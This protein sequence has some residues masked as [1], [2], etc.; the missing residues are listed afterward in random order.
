MVWSDVDGDGFDEIMTITV[1]T[2]LTS[3]STRQ[4]KVYFDGHSTREWE[5]TDPISVDITA[6]VLTIVF[7]FW[8]M[9]DPALQ[10]VFPSATLEALDIYDAIYVTAVDVYREYTDWSQHSAE[11]FWEPRV[12]TITCASC[13]GTGCTACQLTVQC[14]CLYVRDV[15]RGI[16]VPTPGDW[17][18]TDGAW[19]STAFSLCYEPDQVKLWYY[20]GDMDDDYVNGQ[21]VSPLK[22]QYAEA[23]AWMAT[24]RLERNFCNCGAL[25][26][27]A[28]DLRKDLS[29]L[30]RDSSYIVPDR[31]LDNP[32]GTRKGEVM[33][34]RRLSRLIKKR[35]AVALV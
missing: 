35:P 14:G 29:F 34:W 32:F 11:F 20:A 31:D 17:N 24:A 18:A 22:R 33:A 12:Q 2:T 19:A 13:G 9:I 3:N 16:V 25:T 30:G 8:S 6:G 4:I 21:A 27:L 1:A 5:I 28:T 26:A 23:I 7:N 15:H 10:D